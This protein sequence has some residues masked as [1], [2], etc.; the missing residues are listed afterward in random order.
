MW[1]TVG[2][3]LDFSPSTRTD[4]HLASRQPP[5]CPAVVHGWNL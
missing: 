4:A 3:W 1:Q 5:P 2:D